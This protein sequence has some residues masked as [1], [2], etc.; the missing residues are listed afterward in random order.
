MAD[1]IAVLERARTLELEIKTEIEH[2]EQL[3]R[4][5]KRAVQSSAY[6]KETVEKLARLEREV[7]DTSDRMCDAKKE[8]LT[9][10]SYLTGEER[11]VIEG[12]YILAKSW[13]RL[14]NDLYMSERRVYLLR[15]S[16]L[17]KLL[18]RYGGAPPVGS[19]KRTAPRL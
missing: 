15:K 3:H 7:N 1:V 18:N 9:Y 8:A 4:I 19:T 11:S 10:I 13:Q 17:T 14:A 16:A 5:S 2:I 12:Y 6:A